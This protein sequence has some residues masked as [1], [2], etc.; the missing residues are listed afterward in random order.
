M[1][2]NRAYLLKVGIALALLFSGFEYAW[3][4]NRDVNP[5]LWTARLRNLDGVRMWIP[6]ATVEDVGNGE[7]TIRV[8]EYETARVAGTGPTKGQRIALVVTWHADRCQMSCW[9]PFPFA[10]YNVRRIFDGVSLAVLVIVGFLLLRRY[11]LPALR[12]ERRG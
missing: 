12:F 6:A 11:R 7:F 10:G 2:S 8:G 9:E 5:A 4:A 3:R 1:F